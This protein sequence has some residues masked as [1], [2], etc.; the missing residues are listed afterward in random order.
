M[1]NSLN[2][3]SSPYVIHL[4]RL[5]WFRSVFSLTTSLVSLFFFLITL[6]ELLNVSDPRYSQLEFPIC[7]MRNKCV[8]KYRSTSLN[9]IKFRWLC[10]LILLRYGFFF[11]SSFSGD[12]E[13]GF[14]H[15][16]RNSHLR[17]NY[18]WL[19]YAAF[20]VPFNDYTYSCNYHRLTL[21]NFITLKSLFL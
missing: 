16:S 9:L 3:N 12:E 2:E 10:V 6:I 20:N 13:Q 19:L 15:K 1:H 17:M 21:S 7:T 11:F 8:I 5:V 18:F 4:F 14:N